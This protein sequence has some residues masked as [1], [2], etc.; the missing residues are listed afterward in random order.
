MSQQSLISPSD[1]D[2]FLSFFS[3]NSIRYVS[4]QKN[5]RIAYRHFIHSKNIASKLLILVNGRAENMLKWAE[6]AHDFYQLGYD[7]LLFDHRGQGYSQRLHTNEKGHLDRF[8]FY[9]DDMAKIITN[10]TALTSYENQYLIAHSLGALISCHYLA[11]HHHNIEKAVL[12]APFFGVPLKSPWRDK[13][14]IKLMILLGQGKRYVFGKKGFRP[15]DPKN[16]ALSDSRSRMARMNKIHHKYPQ[17]RLGGPTFRWLYLCLNA[18]KSLPSI[19]PNIKIPTLIL[20]AEK[21]Q[22]V[23]NQ[24]LSK[25]TALFPNA[26]CKIVPN[27]KHEILFETTPL[28][29]NVINQILQFLSGNER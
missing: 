1:T 28:R 6:L 7:I 11:T 29:A 24:T 3:Q 9:V 27:A 21:E 25:L 15:V 5:I 10:V 20:Q 13:F 2:E 4:G 8:R 19:L 14:I 16:N 26:E 22:I 12:S 17:L 23:N 18:I